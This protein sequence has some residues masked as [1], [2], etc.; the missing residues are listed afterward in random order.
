MKLIQGDCLEVMKTLPDES[1]D[2]IITDP[3]Y[4]I[5]YQ[6]TWLTDK[7]AWFPKIK[8]DEAPFVDFIPE[9]FRILKSGGGMIS[10][11]RWDVQEAFLSSF[12][13]AGFHAKAQL[14]WD[15][16][17]HGMGDPK[18]SFAPQHECALFL[19]KGAWKVP[20]KRPKSIYRVC[21]VDAEKMV[22]PTEKPIMLIEKMITDI[23]HKGDTILDC[24]MG[25]GST[26]IACVNTERDFIGIELDQNYFDIASGR[27]N[28]AL[29]IKNRSD[30]LI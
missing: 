21:R 2:F 5:T 14:I 17:I 19:E 3:P 24:F 4:G 9:S 28:K 11:Y 20:G 1:V 10:F 15:K 18:G 30:R 12:A 7:S 13:D 29:A 6:S 26:G 8:N 16:V 22:H 23:S 27:I 25:S